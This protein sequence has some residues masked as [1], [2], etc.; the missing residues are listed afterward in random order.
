MP[1][2]RDITTENLEDLDVM[3]QLGRVAAGWLAITGRAGFFVDKDK[4]VRDVNP[5]YVYFDPRAKDES[6]D[7][8]FKKVRP[9]IT[10]RKPVYVLKD[11][12]ELWEI[13]FEEE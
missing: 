3:L 13:E 10:D 6:P 5:F 2:D 4:S 1:D 12:N 7:K 9:I 8:K 11:G